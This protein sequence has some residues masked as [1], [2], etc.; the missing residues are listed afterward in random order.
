MIDHL[1]R[2]QPAAAVVVTD[3]YIERLEE[4]WM[5]TVAAVRLHA[6]VTRDGSSA[7]LERAGIPCTQLGSLPQ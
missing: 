5:A 3:G 4:S 6:V 2:T 7:E 1:A